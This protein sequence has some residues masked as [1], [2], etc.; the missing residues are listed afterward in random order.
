MKETENDERDREALAAASQLATLANEVLGSPV[1]GG[2]AA[3]V[4]GVEPTPLLSQ[5]ELRRF[6]TLLLR[7]TWDRRDDLQVVTRRFA[8]ALLDQTAQR[9]LTPRGRAL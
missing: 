9:A 1:A 8:V 7:K 4:D 5:E 2:A 6:N 3:V